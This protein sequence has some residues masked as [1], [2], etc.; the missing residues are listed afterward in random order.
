VVTGS[1]SGI[2]RAIALEFAEAGAD[3]LVH[4]HRSKR[5]AEKTAELAG[6]RGVRALVTRA[7]LSLESECSELVESAWMSLGGCDIWVNN[8]GADTL[9][10]AAAQLAFDKKL[11]L[12]WAVDVRAT[13]LLSRAVACRMREMGGGVILNMGWDKADTGMEG[14]SGQLFGATK[15]AIMAFSKSL[16]LTVAP[17]VRVN[18]LAPGWIRTRWGEHAS[19]TWQER[20]VRETPLGR[21]GTPEDV[22]RV[23]RFLCSDAAAFITGQVVRVNGGAVR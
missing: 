2:G 23:A 13:A 17:S 12:L 20:A 1:S 7:D 9:T 21:W 8:A 15:A 18:C 5:D 3:L 14:D 16:A 10:R 22:A 4:Y 6:Q 11:D 19:E